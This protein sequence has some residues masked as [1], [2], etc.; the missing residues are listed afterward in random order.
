MTS[1]STCYRVQLA[2]DPHQ[3]PWSNIPPHC[4][5]LLLP[6]F[7]SPHAIISTFLDKTPQSEPP[8]LSPAMAVPDGLV[9]GTPAYLPALLAHL[10]SIPELSFPPPVFIP[11]LLCLIVGEKNLVLRT[12]EED[13]PK[14]VNLVEK[15][16]SPLAFHCSSKI[17]IPS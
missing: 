8:S 15:V 3:L 11:I 5:P 17:L 1:N 12:K 13:I 4:P 7:A 9:P 6:A 14:L 10:R 16:E 2:F